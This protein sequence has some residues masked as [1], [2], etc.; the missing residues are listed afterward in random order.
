MS[1]R[2]SDPSSVP[3]T[4]STVGDI[5]GLGFPLPLPLLYTVP[6]RDPR[7]TGTHPCDGGRSSPLEER[8]RRVPN[9]LDTLT[10]GKHRQS[11]VSDEGRHRY[12]RC[13]WYRISS[14]LR[15]FQPLYRKLGLEVFNHLEPVHPDSFSSKDWFTGLRLVS[16]FQR[17]FYLTWAPKPLHDSDHYRPLPVFLDDRFNYCFYFCGLVSQTLS[18]PPVVSPRPTNVSSSGRLPACN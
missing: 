11:W 6:L 1:S 3:V 5:H 15:H 2:Y 17:Y 18:P 9:G 4:P 7:R 14:P 16:C 12:R 13:H 10:T 8:R